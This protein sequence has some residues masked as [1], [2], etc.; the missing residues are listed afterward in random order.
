MM[1]ERKP[2][3]ANASLLTVAEFSEALA[4]SEKTTR[5]WIFVRKITTHRVGRCVRIPV[6]EVDRLLAE[7]CTPALEAR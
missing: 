1:L 2:S 7:G 4:I 6:S 5:Q 3:G